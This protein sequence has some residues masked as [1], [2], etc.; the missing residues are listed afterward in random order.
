M[1]NNVKY[2]RETREKAKARGTGLVTVD[3]RTTGREASGT[4]I[5]SPAMTE[6]EL[7]YFAAFSIHLISGGKTPKEAWDLTYGSPN[8]PP[9][10]SGIR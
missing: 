10:V 9:S 8:C 6:E 2:P 1:R 7:D 5:Q 4:T 3:T